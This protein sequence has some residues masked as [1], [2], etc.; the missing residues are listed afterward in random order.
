[1]LLFSTQRRFDK[2]RE[3]N[4]DFAPGMFELRVK[5]V[6]AYQAAPNACPRFVHVS[7]G[8]TTRYF[9]KDEFAEED[10]PPA[11]RMNDMIGRVMEYKLSGED[12][13]RVGLS[14]ADCGYTIIRPCALTEKPPVGMSSLQIEQ[15][16]SMTGQISRNDIARV[17]VEALYTPELRNKTFEVAEVRIGESDA[18]VPQTLA[19][20]APKLAVD[21]DATER[22]FC[23]FPFVPL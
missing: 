14:S 19:T 20:V 3:L 23:P 5:P 12:A 21:A 6:L 16:D 2:D 17:C 18:K 8:G 10:L 9:R 11:V 22:T 15:G 13:V 7:S 4:P 1:M